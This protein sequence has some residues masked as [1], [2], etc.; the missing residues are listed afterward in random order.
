MSTLSVSLLGPFEA[1]LDER[2]LHKF[3]TSKVQ[4]LLIYLATEASVVHRRDG[5]MAL[6]WPGLPQKSAQLFEKIAG[7]HIRAAAATLPPEVVEAAQ[8]RGRALDWWEVA[9]ELLAE[10]RQVG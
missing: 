3:R 10:L 8:A 5:L 7:G 1:S 6:L 4:A 9:Q 2:P